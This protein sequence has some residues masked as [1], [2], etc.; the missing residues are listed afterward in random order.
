M[1]KPPISPVDPAA[2]VPPV[3]SRDPGEGLLAGSTIRLFG[4]KFAGLSIGEVGGAPASNNPLAQAFATAR[5][6]EKAT[7]ARIYGFSYLGNYFKLAEPLVYLVHGDGAPLRT[8]GG[9]EG[10]SVGYAG[11]ETTYEEF[12]DGVCMWLVDQLDVSVRVDITI[13][14]MKDILLAQEMGADNNMT[15][16]DSVRRSDVVGRDG[17]NLV[18]RDGNLVGRDGNLIGGGSRR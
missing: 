5:N 2:T 8:A 4:R 9:I 12:T 6:G 11:F 3:A 7:L 1:S 17:G 18:G 16:G 10:N 15:G 13:G 14:W